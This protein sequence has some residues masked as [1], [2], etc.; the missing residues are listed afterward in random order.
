MPIQAAF[1]HVT[2]Y[3]GYQ[4]I[5]LAKTHLNLFQRILDAICQVCN[6]LHL[7]ILKWAKCQELPA[8][9]ENLQLPGNC[10]NCTNASPV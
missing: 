1:G 6:Q 4:V 8:L 2:N 5:I 9:L 10:G 7:G 3:N